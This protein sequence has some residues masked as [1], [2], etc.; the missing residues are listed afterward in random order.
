MVVADI[1]QTS[2]LLG[3]LVVTLH[4]VLTFPGTI[5][6]HFQDVVNVCLKV[7]LKSVRHR[8]NCCR[9]PLLVLAYQSSVTGYIE[10]S[11]RCRRINRSR[12]FAIY[13]PLSCNARITPDRS[14]RSDGVEVFVSRNS[15]VRCFSAPVGDIARC[16]YAG[17]DNLRILCGVDVRFPDAFFT[18]Y[19][20]HAHAGPSSVFHIARPSIDSNGSAVCIPP[21]LYILAV[22]SLDGSQRSD[23]LLISY[24]DS[25]QSNLAISSIIRVLALEHCLLATYCNRR[26]G[27]QLRFTHVQRTVVLGRVSKCYGLQFIAFRSIDAERAGIA[28]I[29]VKTPVL[30][31]LTVVTG[32]N[33]ISRDDFIKLNL[34]ILGTILPAVRLGIIVSGR[35]VDSYRYIRCHHGTCKKNCS[36]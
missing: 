21:A 16:V 28:T 18:C 15:Q 19:S 31:V 6:G 20:F 29:G 27:S 36:Q 30:I 1:Q 35:S 25:R 14:S 2:S 11:R 32:T 9:I 5:Q 4:V 26:L 12:F 10:L 23:S 17:E 24:C 13:R 34:V 7:Q 8:S 22:H 3:Q 33:K